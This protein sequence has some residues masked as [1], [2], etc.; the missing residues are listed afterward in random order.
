MNSLWII[1]LQISR[2]YNHSEKVM[3]SLC[4]SFCSPTSAVPPSCAT[5]DNVDK[6]RE[7][8]TPHLHSSTQDP[9]NYNKLSQHLLTP[10]LDRS[11]IVNIRK[12]IIDTLSTSRDVSERNHAATQ[13]LHN[14]THPN[15][16]FSSIK[17]ILTWQNLKSRHMGV[18]QW[19]TQ[20][21]PPVFHKFHMMFT[22]FYCSSAVEV[23]LHCVL[24]LHAGL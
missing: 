24:F 21:K 22:C 20:E 16:G 23:F 5:V 8:W 1:K 2:I 12:Q 17:V 9:S 15:L 14:D 11:A 19:E 7:A 3:Q 4:R 18:S 10:Q 6:F 13:S